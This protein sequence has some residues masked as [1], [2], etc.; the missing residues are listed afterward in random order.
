MIAA[1]LIIF[2]TLGI[3]TTPQVSSLIMSRSTFSFLRVSVE[4]L[5]VP[6]AVL[7]QRM[8]KT[9]YFTIITCMLRHLPAMSSELLCSLKHSD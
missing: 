7:V 4:F 6:L 5:Q 2:D 3:N 8:K 9:L 1:D